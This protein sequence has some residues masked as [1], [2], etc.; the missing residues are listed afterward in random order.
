MTILNRF[1]HWYQFDITDI[2]A[3]IY[4]F[5]VGGIINGQNMNL[6]FTIGVIIS[7]LSVL[8]SG[9]FNLL[10]INGVMLVLNLYNLFLA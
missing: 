8:K 2:V 6:L 10:L 1:V 5:C 9:R 3:I 4:T 7:L